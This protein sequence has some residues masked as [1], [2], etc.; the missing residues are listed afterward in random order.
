MLLE[1]LPELKASENQ[2][3]IESDYDVFEADGNEMLMRRVKEVGAIQ[4]RDSLAVAV[5]GPLNGAKNLVNDPAN[6]I[7]NVP[8][9]MMKFMGRAGENLKKVGQKGSQARH[10]LE[11]NLS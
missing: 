1:E 4:S 2:F 10:R 6:T 3:V 5:K 8:T 7:S 11:C 9:G